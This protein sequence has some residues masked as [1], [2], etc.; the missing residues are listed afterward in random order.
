[1]IYRLV[2]DPTA[3]LITYLL[4]GEFLGSISAVIIIEV[5]STIFYY[6]LDRLM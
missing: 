5:F 3:I 4:T 2:V 1:M 6:L